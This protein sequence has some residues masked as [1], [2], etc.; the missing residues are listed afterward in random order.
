M[1]GRHPRDQKISWGEMN[2]SNGPRW[3][4][5]YCSDFKC[6]HSVVIDRPMG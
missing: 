3:L 5:V 2:S 1:S 4:I 6:S